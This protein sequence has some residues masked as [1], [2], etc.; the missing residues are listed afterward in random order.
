[1][2]S[3]TAKQSAITKE[4]LP[5]LVYVSVLFLALALVDARSAAAGVTVRPISVVM[6]APVNT[7]KYHMVTIT[8]SGPGTETLV[9]GYATAGSDFWVT[10]GGTCNVTYAYII[11]ANKSCTLQW[12]FKP[13]V[14]GPV[15]A[16]GSIM[17]EGGTTLD[18]FLNGIGK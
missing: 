12:G 15:T 4:I 11:P 18:I 16:S 9:G 6:R 14:K 17:F 5:T 7:Y 2:R 13:T 3:R 8:N 10:W 1:M